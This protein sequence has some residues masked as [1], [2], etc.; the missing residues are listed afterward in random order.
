M[1]TLYMAYGSNLNLQQ[2]AKRCPTAKVFGT[3]MLEDYQLVFQGVATI[4]PQ[5][6]SVVPVAIWEI[7]SDCE[8]A[9]DR[10]EGFP[11]LYRKEYM[12]IPVNGIEQN[13]M[14]YIM[15]NGTAAL[16]SERYY[17]TIEQG[18]Y[19]VGFDIIHLRNALRATMK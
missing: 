13:V 17:R 18:Y 2:M 1:K 19:D 7:D 8:K 15:N 14:V 5:K 12:I 9:L 10:Y 3:A 4:K 16:P 11:H 6:G